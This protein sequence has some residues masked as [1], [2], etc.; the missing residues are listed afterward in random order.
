MLGF[1][2]SAQTIESSVRAAIAEPEIKA[3]V[4]DVDS[5]GG[6]ATGVQ[7][8]AAELRNMRGQ[9]PIVAHV[10]YMAASAAY[11]IASSADEIVASPSAYVGSV[12]AFI[13]HV[14]QSELLKQVGI[15]VTLIAEPEQKVDG[16]SFEPLSDRAR[17]E[18]Q[19][20]VSQA[21]DH[22]RA[23]VAAGRGI[24]RSDISDQ[25]A[26]TFTAR[27]ALAMGMIDKIRTFD[28]TLAAYGVSRTPPV[29]GP[30][31]RAERA[32]PAGAIAREIREIEALLAVA[33]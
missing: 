15:D 4:M 20:L 30:A 2:T 32:V 12:G 17:G 13:T 19:T 28:Q 23:D 25:W 11:W 33:G 21:V 10:D 5:P 24:R 26:H 7:E 3:I 18:L 8:L 1:G 29:K 31:N 27:D 14:D 6:L 22:F 9:K 16:N